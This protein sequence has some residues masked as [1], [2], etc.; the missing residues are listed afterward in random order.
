[1]S[2][3]VLCG[4]S[5]CSE[6]GCNEFTYNESAEEHINNSTVLFSES[7]GR[8]IVT[9]APENRSTFEKLFKGMACECVGRVTDTHSNF[10]V[11]NIDNIIANISIDRLAQAWKS[12]L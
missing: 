5:E 11:K 6:F 7:A 3:A 9:V 12:I 2:K 8:F 1:M 4:G 10:I